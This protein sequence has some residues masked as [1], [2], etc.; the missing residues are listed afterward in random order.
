MYVVTGHGCAYGLRGR[1]GLLHKSWRFVTND[2]ELAKA[3]SRKC[4][5]PSPWHVHEVVGG[6]VTKQSQNY[7]VQLAKVILSW[8]RKLVKLNGDALRYLPDEKPSMYA[9]RVSCA[10]DQ[11]EPAGV[12]DIPL[13]CEVFFLDV[14]RDATIWRQ[15]LVEAERWLGTASDRNRNVSEDSPLFSRIGEH[16]PWDIARIQVSRTP[17]ARRF[18]TN[19]LKPVTHRAQVLWYA[20]DSIEIESEAMKDVSRHSLRFSRPVKLAIFIFGVAPESAF[21]PSGQPAASAPASGSLPSPSGPARS[22]AP[23]GTDA[24]SGS[25]SSS[26]LAPPPLRGRRP[27]R[28]PARAPKAGASSTPRW[29]APATSFPRR[30]TARSSGSDGA[31]G[32]LRRPARSVAIGP[33]LS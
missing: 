31:G 8:L 4:P 2:P 27:R 1:S 29:R 17:A 14:V 26:A 24:G 15:S 12:F 30:I 25:A 3:L 22:L 23:A 28:V 5:G 16:V 33:A 13:E 10:H 21:E 19:V 7:P 18:P 6:N 20:D 32:N 11:W 9:W